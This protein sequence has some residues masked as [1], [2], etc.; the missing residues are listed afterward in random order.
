MVLGGDKTFEEFFGG[1]AADIQDGLKDGHIFLKLE[2]GLSDLGEIDLAFFLV[3]FQK[4]IAYLLPDR[5]GK[6][7]RYETQ[8]KSDVPHSF[9]L[10]AAELQVREIDF[11]LHGHPNAIDGLGIDQ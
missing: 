10:P 4:N 1:E 7:Y 11:L 9:I 6:P 8:K 2:T 3:A 5:A